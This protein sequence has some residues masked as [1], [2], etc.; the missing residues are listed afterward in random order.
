MMI[1]RLLSLVLITS[2]ITQTILANEVNQ[3]SNKFYTEAILKYNLLANNILRT[4]PQNMAFMK[5]YLI[6]NKITSPLPLAT[7]LDNNKIELSLKG[8]KILVQVLDPFREVIQ[9]NDTII[10]LGGLENF[11]QKFKKIESVFAMEGMTAQHSPRL[12]LLNNFISILI[13]NAEADCLSKYENKIKEINADHPMPERKG[14]YKLPYPAS[15]AF[16]VGMLVLVLI[17]PSTPAMYSVF[18]G[19]Y[20]FNNKAIKLNDQERALAKLYEK[21]AFDEVLVRD[22]IKVAQKGK[23]PDNDFSEINFYKFFY[24]IQGMNPTLTKEE[25]VKFLV[26]GDKREIFCA[27]SLM[28]PETIA[29]FYSKSNQAQAISDSSERTSKPIEETIIPV[30]KETSATLK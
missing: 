22:A 28:K 29:E 12:N 15:W 1:S 4:A 8:H 5:N 26:Y 11:N 3:G 14:I 7:L 6:N 23:L 9:I 17:P 25:F 13:T 19:T 20:F 18:G 30:A 10:T 24:A 2:L 27:K 16:A 21:T